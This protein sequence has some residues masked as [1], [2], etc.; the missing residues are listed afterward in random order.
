MSLLRIRA[1][2]RKPPTACP[3]DTLLRR[4]SPPGSGCPSRRG[5][6]RSRRRARGAWGA[7]LTA[8]PARPSA[9][10]CRGRSASTWPRHDR[11]GSAGRGPP[12]AP[13]S[14]RPAAGRAAGRN[15]P[16]DHRHAARRA[17]A[18]DVAAR[19]ALRAGP[20]LATGDW[21]ERGGA[22]PAGGR[23]VGAPCPPLLPGTQVRRPSP[24]PWWTARRGGASTCRHCG[25]SRPLPPVPL[26]TETGRT[27]LPPTLDYL[28]NH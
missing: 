2:S 18:L 24:M 22:P 10:R 6:R 7:G 8:L 15:W 16:A 28:V 3:A 14:A 21:Q 11:P 19:V 4:G 13:G 27:H 20:P 12:R 5:G 26:A 25:T 17:L 1:L 23:R 9:V